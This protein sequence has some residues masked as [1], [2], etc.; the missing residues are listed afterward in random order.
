MKISPIV[1]GLLFSMAAYLLFSGYDVTVKHLAR[2]YSVYQVMTV[3]YGLATLI[4]LA[5]AAFLARKDK[6]IFVIRKPWLHVGRGLAQCVSALLFFSGFTAMPL[7]DF[8]IFVFLIPIFVALLS[9][10]FLKEKLTPAL[11]LTVL[12]SF[13]GVLIAVGP[14]G[15]WGTAYMLVLAGAVINAI[16]VLFLRRLAA[17]EPQSI[18]AASVCFFMTV[19][20]LMFA[21]FDWRPVTTDFLLVAG[22]GGLFYGVAMILVSYAFRLAPAGIA[23]VPQFLQLIYGA[24]L[25]LLV[26]GEV[27]PASIFVG[28]AMVIAANLAMIF[29]QNRKALR[30]PEGENSVK[31]AESK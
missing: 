3:A 21:V 6:S 28:G 14:R 27:P 30:L 16:G 7:T 31:P 9:V 8:Y 15:E 19:G 1:S 17:T 26:F 22:L 5:K 12:V 11:V 4:S 18:M 29:Y 24:I 20:S 25:G 23:S 13:A 2:H 10:P